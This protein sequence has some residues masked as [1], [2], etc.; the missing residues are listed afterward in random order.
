MADAGSGETRS[1]ISGGIQQR[2]VLQGW[3]FSNITFAVATAAAAAAS[4]ALALLPPQVAGFSG[5]DD[6]LAVITGLLDPD[7]PDERR[8]GLGCGGLGVGRLRSRSRPN[9]SSCGSSAPAIP[10]AGVDRNA[11]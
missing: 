9:T 7:G 5:R 1:T 11:R 10:R 4:V 6:E 3:D 2:P 8:R